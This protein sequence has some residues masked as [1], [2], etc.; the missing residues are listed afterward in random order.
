M[1]MMILFVMFRFK[2]WEI[3]IIFDF[4]FIVIVYYKLRKLIFLYYNF[5]F[6]IVLIFDVWEINFN[7]KNNII[8]IMKICM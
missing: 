5:F 7:F 1:V 4:L 6:Y 3:G 8:N 2:N